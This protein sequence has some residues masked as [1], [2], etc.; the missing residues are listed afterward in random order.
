MRRL[1]QFIGHVTARV[2][3]AE[4]A[5]AEAALPPSARTLFRAMPVAD[6]RHAID[7]AARLASV[8]HHDRDLVTAAL[9]HDAAKGARMRLWHRV[10]GVVLEALAPRL[11]RRL[12]SPREASPLHGF[13]L[14]L[15]HARL[16]AEAARDAGCGERVAR[17]IRGDVPEQ[18][19]PL[20]AALH[21]ADAA[22]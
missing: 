16:S 10:A 12:A 1:R 5:R 18:D 9:L 8:G 13:Y 3:V 4:Q 7:V 22:S 17:F 20:L 19:A 11:L 2:E 15:E 6:R 21:R 14:Y